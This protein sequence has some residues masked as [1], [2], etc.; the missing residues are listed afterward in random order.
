MS[1]VIS[2]LI[3]DQLGGLSQDQQARVLEFVQSLKQPEKKGTPGRN[4]RRF[5]G[6]ISKED[7]AIMKAAIEAECEQI[8]D[9][10]W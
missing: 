2:D 6:T 8:D 5:V 7:L 9:H 1:N 3:T 4:L 10:D